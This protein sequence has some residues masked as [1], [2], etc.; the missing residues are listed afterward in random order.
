MISIR[1]GRTGRTTSRRIG[2]GPAMEP[3][4]DDKELKRLI[5]LDDPS[6]LRAAADKLRREWY[7]TDVYVRG[8][9]EFSN[10]CKNNCR[11]CG[12]R[13]GNPS[14]RRYRLAEEE[15]IALTSNGYG[16]GFRTFVLQSGEDPAFDDESICRI[17]RGIK[18]SHPDCAVTLSIGEKPEESYRKYFEAGASRYLLRHETADEAHYRRLHPETMS[19]GNRKQCLRNLKKIGFQVGAGFMVGSPYQTLDN[20]V[21]DLRFL[22][23]LQPDMI[24]IGPFIPAKGTPFEN[25][26]QGSLQMTLNLISIL[27]IMFPYALIPATTALGSVDPDGM[28]LGLKA[29][30]NVI[31]PDLTPTAFGKHYSIYDHKSSIKEEATVT[32]G[33]LAKL[34][35][36]AGYRIVIDRG[37][38]KSH[39]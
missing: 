2:N 34:V 8:L 15:I 10:H 16:L 17:I 23:E 5:T 37:D 11:Y 19:L 3:F 31:M 33:S 21:A 20:L 9:I 13:A 14:V 1:I 26:P 6:P 35:R 28:I 27:R 7:G 24:G 36:S 18:T 32:D 38:V 25:E 39:S 12:I 22:Q 30:A 29:G 4:S